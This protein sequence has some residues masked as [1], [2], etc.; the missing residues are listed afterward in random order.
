[1]ALMTCGEVGSVDNLARN[2]QI[3][4]LTSLKSIIEVISASRAGF[5]TK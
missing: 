5:L 4:Y 3:L 2:N 1:M